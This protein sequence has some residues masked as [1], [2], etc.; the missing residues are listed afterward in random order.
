MILRRKMRRKRSEEILVVT[1][2]PFLE[3]F[4][5]EL[6]GIAQYKAHFNLVVHV[7]EVKTQGGYGVC[8]CV[9][10]CVCVCVWQNTQCSLIG[11]M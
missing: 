4:S 7:V 6:L 5:H 11:N 3:V 9:C 1:Y 2:C 10:V 8:M